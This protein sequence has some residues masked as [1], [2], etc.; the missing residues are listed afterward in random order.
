MARVLLAS[1][2]NWL[3]PARM[4]WMLARAGIECDVIDIGGTYVSSSSHVRKRTVI[5]DDPDELATAVLD[6][7]PGYDRVLLCNE[8][9]IGRVLRVGGERADH[10]LPA[11]RE[12][13]E[14]LI[15]K[16]RFPAAAEAAGLRV[17]GWEIAKTPWVAGQAAGRLGG[18][19]VVKGR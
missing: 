7:A 1:T 18:R 19:I 6:A 17:A 5:A 8:H 4:P 9:L 10:I 13:C 14:A 16:T 15:N 11:P 2:V 12:S 3:S